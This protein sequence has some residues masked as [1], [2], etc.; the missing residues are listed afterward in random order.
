[1]GW[2]GW[3]RPLRRLLRRRLGGRLGSSCSRNFVDRSNL[4]LILPILAVQLARKFAGVRS[5]L[6][7]LVRLDPA[8]VDESLYH[9]MALAFLLPLGPASVVD[10]P[11]LPAPVMSAEWPAGGMLNS[12]SH[13]VECNNSVGYN[14]GAGEV[15][16]GAR[17]IL[18]VGR[19]L[20]QPFPS[21]GWGTSRG[22]PLGTFSAMRSVLPT[23]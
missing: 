8:I 20:P 5:I 17:S 18:D 7:P 12:G 2:L 13:R 15:F 10:C 1:M 11:F 4:E 9:Q 14:G 21:L 3:G 22:T 6:F 23:A 19:A 16:G